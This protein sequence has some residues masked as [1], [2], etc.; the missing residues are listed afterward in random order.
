[1]PFAEVHPGDLIQ[2]VNL[3]Q[4]VDS[5]NGTAG[6]GQP[7]LLVA[8]NDPNN[9]A[10]TVQNLDPTNCRALMVLKNDGTPLLSAGCTGVTLGSPLNLAAGSITN[11]D[12]ADGSISNAKLGPDVA[13]ANLLTNGGF[14]ISQRGNIF[15]ANNVMSAD[16]WL[17]I[18]GPG[19]SGGIGPLQTSPVAPGSQYSLLF[20]FSALGAGNPAISQKLEN[21]QALKGMTL[22]VS[23]MAYQ[24]VANAVQVG[25]TDGISGATS[26]LSASVNTWVPLR[27][28]YTIS[29]SATTVVVQISNLVAA[30]VYVDNACLV[31]GSQPADYVPLHPADDLARCLRYYQ[32][33]GV[34]NQIV[35]IGSSG[36][37]TQHNVLVNAQAPLGLT[38][39]ST[40]SA[41]ATITLLSSTL[42]ATTPASTLSSTNASPTSVIFVAGSAAA[43]NAAGSPCYLMLSSGAY[44][45][46][47][48]NP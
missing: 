28:T 3:N 23:L 41:P 13:R 15:T 20:N 31:V 7:V 44:V 46:F 1:M 24:A 29:A 48:A 18:I 6:A 32:R 36:S 8:L 47:E 9:Y 12:L 10:L 39:S 26:P 14:E 21:W 33:W 27:A 38:P 34:M 25:I 42:G 4:I 5:L 19:A 11:N 45:A 40:S 17:T 16:R 30:T 22:S 2:S 43:F 37:T 35:G